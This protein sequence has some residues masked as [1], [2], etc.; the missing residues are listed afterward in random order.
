MHALAQDEEGAIDREVGMQRS[1]GRVLHAMLGPEGLVAV[2]EA[3]RIEGLRALVA[4]RERGV[5]RGMPVLRHDDILE[6]ARQTID[7]RDDLVAPARPP[8]PRQA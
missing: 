4:R 7:E 5:R 3:L 8:A 2:M 1:A 6:S